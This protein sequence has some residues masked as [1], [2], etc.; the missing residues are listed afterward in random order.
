MISVTTVPLGTAS[1]ATGHQLPGVLFQ[2][3][4]ANVLLPVQALAGHLS[5]SDVILITNAENGGA[6]PAIG[7][8]FAQQYLTSFGSVWW[9]GRIPFA[10]ADSL[11]GSTS[12]LQLQL[13]AA[14]PAGKTKVVAVYSN[15]HAAT[16]AHFAFPAI[17]PTSFDPTLAWVSF[18]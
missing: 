18:L 11:W 1:A 9:Y 2:E 3:L 5:G 8:Q 12:T 6:Y 14:A 17:V 16:Y 7:A 4:V 13:S 10:L 15:R